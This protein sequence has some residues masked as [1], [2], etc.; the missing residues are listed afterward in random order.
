MN[1]LRNTSYKLEMN[2]GLEYLR[3]LFIGVHQVVVGSF[4]PSNQLEPKP[5]KLKNESNPAI[6][7]PATTTIA[8]VVPAFNA[9]NEE[10]MGGGNGQ[11]NSS[12]PRPNLAS[13]STFRRENWAI[14]HDSRNSGTDIN[15]SLPGG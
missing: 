1:Y 12:T 14:L 9:E 3:N 11:Q 4:L 10:S 8:T 13:S 15:I 6:A 5:K 7:A 2:R